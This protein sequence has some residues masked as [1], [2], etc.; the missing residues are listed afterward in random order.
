MANTM[1]LI[2]S[3]SVGSG[4][5]SAMNFTSIPQNYNDLKLL[6]TGRIGTSTYGTDIN[7]TFN[8]SSTGFSAARLYGYNSG[9]YSDDGVAFGFTNG[10]SATANTFTSVSMYITKY[11]SNA[12][13]IYSTDIATE[14][15]TTVAYLPG[16]FCGTWANTAAITS[17]GLTSLSNFLEGSTAYL[18][19][20]ENS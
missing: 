5:A 16:L 20:I 19:G 10:T 14:N 13:K 7:G 3:V 17:I 6:I 11:T 15:N 1:K 2:S 9:A 8:G 18:Y 4:G 12:H